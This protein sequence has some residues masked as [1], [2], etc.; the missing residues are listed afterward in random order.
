TAALAMGDALGM[1]LIERR[2][3]TVDD[4]AVLHPGG[5]LG[6]KLLRVEDVMHTGDGV[7]RV[8]PRTLM[9][10]VL[11]EMTKKRLGRTQ[12]VEADGGLVGVLSDGDIRRQLEKHGYTLFERTAGE[13][14]TPEPL[15]IGRRELATRALDRM[16]ARKITALI[17][18]DAAGAVEGVVHLHD[19]WNTEMIWG[20]RGREGR[21]PGPALPGPEARPQRCGRG[22]DRRHPPRLRRRPGGQGL[23]CPR[24]LRDRARPRGRAQDRC[25]FRAD[26]AIGRAPG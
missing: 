7:P 17:V 25:G 15:V 11:F 10:D 9:K 6:K 21:T 23:P 26:V 4:F 1:A 13:C 22:D 5:K 8:E 2:G 24:R 20:A 12:V 16:E 14:M 3:F 19:L 18:T